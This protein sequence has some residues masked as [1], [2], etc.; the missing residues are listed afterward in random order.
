MRLFENLIFRFFFSKE[1]FV[2]KGSPSILLIFC[3]RMDTIRESWHYI[4]TILRFT[5]QEVEVRET[6]LP[7]LQ[8][9]KIRNFDVISEVNWAIVRR[10]S[11]F[12][13]HSSTLNPNFWSVFWA[14]GFSWKKI[15]IFKATPVAILSRRREKRFLQEKRSFDTR[16]TRCQRASKSKRWDIY[17]CLCWREQQ[18]FDWKKQ[19]RSNSITVGVRG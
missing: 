4:R 1:N 19:Q 18:A 16:R 15:L 2:S 12:K 5:K 11:R 9:R 6:A 7:F 14:F 17:L 3:N 13:K 10:R 8:A